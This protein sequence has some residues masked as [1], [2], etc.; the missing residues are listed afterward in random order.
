MRFIDHSLLQPIP[1][2][3]RVARCE[4]I[5]G[6]SSIYLIEVD[7]RVIKIPFGKELFDPS[8]SSGQRHLGERKKTFNVSRQYSVRRFS[9]K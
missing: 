5:L 2:P 6:E 7:Y 9:V 8:A 1:V 4:I 3:A